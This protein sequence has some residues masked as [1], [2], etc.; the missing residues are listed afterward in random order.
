MECVLDLE[1]FWTRA[2]TPGVADAQEGQ[3]K[4]LHMSQ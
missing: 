4:E 3:A 1:L 2:L